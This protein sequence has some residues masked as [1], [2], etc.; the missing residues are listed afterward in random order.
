MNTLKILNLKI[1]GNLEK[2]GRIGRVQR[3]NKAFSLFASQHNN[4]LTSFPILSKVLSSKICTTRNTSLFKSSAEKLFF[5]IELK[6]NDLV[7]KGLI[8]EVDIHDEFMNI[9]FDLDGKI[10]TIVISKQ[11][12][13][14][15]I[16]YSS[17]LRKPDYFEFGPDWKSLRTNSTLFQ[18][19][20]ED[21]QKATG[22]YVNF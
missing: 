13:A 7:D 19:L 4:Y 20:C 18:V 22:I 3:K 8:Y 9:T 14:N 6:L 15:Q 12:A 11:T 5:D 10:G 2:F 1:L 17:P 16:W 21:L